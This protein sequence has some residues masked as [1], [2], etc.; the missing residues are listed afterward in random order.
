MISFTDNLFKR[1][2]RIIKMDKPWIQSLT[3]CQRLTAECVYVPARPWQSASFRYRLR[4]A[5]LVFT[6]RADALVWSGGQ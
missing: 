5:W 1:A 6:G 4:C 2:P 3:A